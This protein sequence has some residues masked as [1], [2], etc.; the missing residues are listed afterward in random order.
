MQLKERR[1]LHQSRPNQRPRPQ[2]PNQPSSSTP[3]PAPPPRPRFLPQPSSNPQWPGRPAHPLPSR[4]LT[5]PAHQMPSRQALLPKALTRH[6]PPLRHRHPR[7][8]P[9]P[10]P[11]FH[12]SSHPAPP[13]GACQWIVGL[14][15]AGSH[16]RPLQQQTLAW[17]LW[18]IRSWRRRAHL[19]L[20][21]CRLWRIRYSS[22]KSK[23]HTQTSR[24]QHRTHIH[25]QF[26]AHF[27]I[28][29]FL[30]STEAM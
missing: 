12:P 11:P 7:P 15:G 5:L 23:E 1:S 4:H 21:L 18:C 30:H 26:T 25:S 27:S 29:T 10:A 8:L 6:W 9:L 19:W 20:L 16:H 17:I 3:W 13:L 22:T 24:Y 28:N 2:H 14:Q